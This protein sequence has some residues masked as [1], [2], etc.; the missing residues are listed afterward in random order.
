ML[1]YSIL[2]NFPVK[3]RSLLKIAFNTF[4]LIL[5]N[6]DSVTNPV[7]GALPGYM[8]VS[9]CIWALYAQMQMD[10]VLLSVVMV[11]LI[12]QVGHHNHN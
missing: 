8:V 11:D 2:I 1:R 12:M 6:F 4:T 3:L 9:I 10:R 7:Y 5:I